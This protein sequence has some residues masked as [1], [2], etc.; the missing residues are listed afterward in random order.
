MATI[1]LEDDPPPIVRV[2]GVTLRRAAAN[3]SLAETIDRL[4]GKVALRSTKDPQAATIHFDRGAVTIR[5]GVA[6]DAD[7]VISADLDTMGHPGAPSPKVK[8]VAR[9]PKLALAMSKVLDP[10]L[11]GGWRG[12]AERMWR[13]IDGPTRP[14]RLHLVCTDEHDELV[15]GDADPTVELHAPAWVLAAVLSGGDHPGTAMFERRLRIVGD[16]PTVNRLYGLM[17]RRMLGEL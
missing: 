17:G 11:E 7:L 5:H 3:R 14:G 1:T 8:G 16:L 4:E 13:A 9:H 2:L 12:E 15:L 10:P 6:T